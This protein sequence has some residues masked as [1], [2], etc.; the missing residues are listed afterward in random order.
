MIMIFKNII[1]QRIINSKYHSDSFI[2]KLETGLAIGRFRPTTSE[3]CS[4][5]PP[6]SSSTQTHRCS[7]FSPEE[8]RFTC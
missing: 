3:T 2:A 8:D 4:P 1:I 6:F 7:S 5:G